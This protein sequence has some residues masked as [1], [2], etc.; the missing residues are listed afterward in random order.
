MGDDCPGAEESRQCD[1]ETADDRN[2]PDELEHDDTDDSFQV[3]TAE[4]W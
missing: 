4:I 1:H 3:R 2:Q